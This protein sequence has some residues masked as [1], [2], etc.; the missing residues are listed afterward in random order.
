MCLHNL[1]HIHYMQVFWTN[2][3]MLLS[4]EYFKPVFTRKTFL[5]I[6]TNI[7][8][9]HPKISF[10]HFYTPVLQVECAID[11]PAVCC[12]CFAGS[13]H[14]P[15]SAGRKTGGPFPPLF[16]P[17]MASGFSPP[18]APVSGCPAGSEVVAWLF[19]SARLWTGAGKQWAGWVQ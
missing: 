6:G 3:L 9:R 11:F 15:R 1:L 19:S 8:A 5:Y 18:R 2:T 17:S 10:W 14:H 4:M 12:L 16:A 13:F 7:A